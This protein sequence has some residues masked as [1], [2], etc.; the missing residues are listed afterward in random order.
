[1]LITSFAKV[2]FP[3][4]L[5]PLLRTLIHLTSLAP[6][7]PQPGIIISYRIRSLPKE[8]P[9]WSA[10][11]LWFSY[12]PVLYRRDR[13]P[14]LPSLQGSAGYESDHPLLNNHSNGDP[15]AK[16]ARFHSPSSTY[17]FIARRKS[18]SLRWSVPGDDKDLLEGVG[19]C[20]NQRQK[21]DDAFELMLL[22][23][24]LNNED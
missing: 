16:W 15:E 13:R 4:L 17:I 3:H 12:E 20:G 14:P 19:A 21:G 22:M 9:F 24:L 1:M 8:I 10:F 11:G 5:A 7:S 6:S 2:Y 23:D 18:S